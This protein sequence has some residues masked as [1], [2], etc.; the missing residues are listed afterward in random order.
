MWGI[1]GVFELGISG[2][3]FLGSRPRKHAL[4]LLGIHGGIGTANLVRAQSGSEEQ[5]FIEYSPRVGIDVHFVTF[6]S[7]SLFVKGGYIFSMMK[8]KGGGKFETRH[9][10][11]ATLGTEFDV[12]FLSRAFSPF[13]TITYASYKGNRHE[14]TAGAGLRY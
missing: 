3:N 7:L 13:I 9:G 11:Y 12:A 6:F 5:M 8:N 14:L 10:G 1:G 2:I 4:T